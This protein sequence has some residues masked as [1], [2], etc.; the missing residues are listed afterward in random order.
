MGSDKA[1][2]PF[3][4]ATLLEHIASRVER[5]AGL[6]TVIAPLDRYRDLRYP[7]VSDMREGCGPLGGVFTA[8]SITDAPWNLIVACDMPGLTAGF[9]EDLFRAAEAGDTDAVVPESSGGLDSLCAVY[10]RRC[11]AKAASAIDRKILKMHDFVSTL[12]IRR[13]TVTNAA[14]LENIN[15]PDEWNHRGSAR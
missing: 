7:V 15:T 3:E 8:L 6:A 2:L 5:V 13:W 14:P 4:G 11:L 9:L 12:R 1:L 10:H